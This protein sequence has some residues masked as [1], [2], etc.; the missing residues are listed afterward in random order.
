MKKPQLAI[1]ISGPDGNIYAVLAKVMQILGKQQRKSDF[2]KVKEKVFNSKSYSKA[3][4]EINE[5]VKLIDIS[6]EK[7]L[8]KELKAG[9]RNE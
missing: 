1:D 2:N 4:C 9:A 6:E 3:L 7:L 5:V 8:E